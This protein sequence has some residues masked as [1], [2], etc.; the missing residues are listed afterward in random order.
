MEVS[1]IVTEKVGSEAELVFET[2]WNPESIA[3]ALAL[4]QGAVK[5]DWVAV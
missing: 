1:L 2:G 3:V 5:V 4:V